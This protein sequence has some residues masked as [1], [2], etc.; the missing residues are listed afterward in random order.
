MSSDRRTTAA[1]SGRPLLTESDLQLLWSRQMYLP[2]RMMTED[3]RPITIEF[4]GVPSLAGPDFRGARVILD[5]E[6]VAGDVELHLVPSGWEIHR[7]ASN[8]EFANV[9]LHVALWRDRDH[10][11][12]SR[13][14]IASTF[15]GQPIPE[16]VLE[17]FLQES[18]AGIARALRESYPARVA[19][20]ADEVG[21]LLDAEGDAR[22]RDKAGH[23]DRLLKALPADEV[24]YRAVMAALGFRSNRSQFEE[25]AARTPVRHLRGR[26][27]ADILA[28]LQWVAGFENG[29]GARPPWL[30]CAG[31]MD[32]ALWRRRGVRP[33]NYPERRIE[34]AAALVAAAGPDGPLDALTRQVLRACSLAPEAASR[35]LTRVIEGWGGPTL[36]ALRAGEIVH[37]VIVPFFLALFRRSESY[38]WAAFM[39]DIWRFTPAPP[40]N[41]C[42]AFVKRRVFGAVEAARTVVTNVR[43]HQGLLG[44]FGRMFA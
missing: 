6:R 19:V 5:G 7:H 14:S 40:D 42:T 11:R 36:G 44:W 27:A 20:P 16:L 2:S 28:A 4:P 33:A 23:V 25:L 18:A 39:R 13:S 38:E 26:S 37:N 3:S 29:A 12:A 8:V 21:R 9:I 32:P 43:R 41:S 35:E 34:A 22:L 17:P 24:L 10:D 15:R 30:E 31:R 1:S